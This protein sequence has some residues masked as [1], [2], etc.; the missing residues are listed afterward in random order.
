MRLRLFVLAALFITGTWA[1]SAQ[2][3][4]LRQPTR[5][6][7]L[8]EQPAQDP[9]GVFTVAQARR[10]QEL[11]KK[12]CSYCHMEELS[13]GGP[14]DSLVVS[15]ALAGKYFREYWR[16]RPLEHLLTKI[17]TTMPKYSP[18]T[19]SRQE[20][21]DLLAF[22]LWESNY[23]GGETEIPAEGDELETIP[24]TVYQ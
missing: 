20:A 21:V 1:V 16:G 24:F 4:A 10:G 14:Q 15:P 17:V 11:Y 5:R 3:P 7:P 8:V 9:N 19:L 12:A 2:Q 23:P 22:I 18:G 13:G 6:R